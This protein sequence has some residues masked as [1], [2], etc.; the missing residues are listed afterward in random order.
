MTDRAKAGNQSKREAAAV[1]DGIELTKAQAKVLRGKIAEALESAWKAGFDDG[2]Q[3]L[4][5]T[6]LFA[7][8]S[9]SAP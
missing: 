8:P 6:R 3:S 7:K 4:R 5:L 1:L 2:V 9:E